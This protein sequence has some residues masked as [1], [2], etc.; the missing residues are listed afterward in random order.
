MPLT[1]PSVPSDT[2][3]D[4]RP[5]RSR[6]D[7][8][9]FKRLP[10]RLMPRGSRWVEP[11]KMVA[12][13]M[14]DRDRHPFYDQGRGAVAEFFLAFDARTRQPVGRIAAII[15]HRY[16]TH[17]RRTE[18]EH[19]LVGLFG[20]LDC[21]DAPPVA[22]RLLDA[23]ADWLRGQGMK[24]MLGPASPSQSYDYGLLVEGHGQPHRF[25]LPF[26]PP[27][28]APLLEACGLTKAK[29]LLALTI[30]LTD[31]Q[32]RANVDRFIERTGLMGARRSAGDVTIRPVNLRRFEDESRIVRDAVNEVLVSS[33]GYTPIS[34]DEWRL[35]AGSLRRFLNADF[36]LVAERAGKPI[37]V[38]LAVPDLNETIS[39]LRIRVGWLEPLEFLLRAWRSPAQ[40]ARIIVAGVSNGG[41]QFGVGPQLIG[42]LA[43][44]LLAHRIRFVDAHLVLEDNR[45]MLAPLLKHGFQ[46]DRRF[47]VYE[48]TL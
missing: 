43:R 23:A 27:Y 45:A 26:H 15:D 32:C 38:T 34:D 14:L 8:R 7:L 28:Y 33:W 29:D 11:L 47:R 46:A 36:V 9:L 10:R 24:R 5:V 40:C 48:R 39:R 30:D 18:P 44:N 6:S 4:V 37:G 16:N 41:D 17:L 21:I 22:R 13:P 42:Q 31:P 19:E 25:L 3:P 12:D 20:F 35:M 2:P 1:P